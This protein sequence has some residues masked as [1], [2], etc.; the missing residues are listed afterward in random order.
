MAR[1]MP[2]LWYA[3]DAEEAARFYVG[4]IPDSRIDR[5]WSMQAESPSGPPGSVKLVEFTIAAPRS[6]RCRRPTRPAGSTN[7]C[8]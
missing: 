2:S 6:R 5:V 1:M 7:R 3:S 4:I 8:R